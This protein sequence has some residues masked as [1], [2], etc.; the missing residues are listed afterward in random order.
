MDSCDSSSQQGLALSTASSSDS[1]SR[2]PANLPRSLSAT[3]VCLWKNCSQS[4]EDATIFYNHLQDHSFENMAGPCQ[5]LDC[6]AARERI[7]RHQPRFMEHHIMQHIPRNA[8]R[9]LMDGCNKCFDRPDKL[10]NHLSKHPQPKK[11]EKPVFKLDDPTAGRIREVPI[12]GA[13]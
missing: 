1:S 7:F 4:G 2:E 6:K 10:N 9:C 3:F 13:G 5:W 11:N 12:D 8:F